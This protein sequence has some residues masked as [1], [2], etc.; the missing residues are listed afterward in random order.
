MTLADPDFVKRLE[1]V[2][3][4]SKPLTKEQVL[5]AKEKLSPYSREIMMKVSNAG[6]CFF[7]WA[8]KVVSSSG[9]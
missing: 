3:S 1:S 6:A 9:Y 5:Y 7:V 2:D 4:L 8:D